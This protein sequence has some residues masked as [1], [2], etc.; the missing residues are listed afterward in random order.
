MLDSLTS[1]L[2]SIDSPLLTR[3]GIRLTIK[4]DDL[5]HP[6]VSG[7][8]WRKLK[9]NL[10]Y[11]SKHNFQGVL[12]FGGAF[13][14][15]IYA[16]AMACK[17]ANL[18]CKLII[19]GL[20]LDPNNPTLKLAK[21]SGAELF[22]VDRKTYR[23]RHDSGYLEF[24]HK[25]HPEYWIVPEGGSNDLALLGLKEL[26]MSLPHSDV[27]ACAVGSGGTLAGITLAAPK[28]TQI[29]GV[30]VLKGASTLKH[31]VLA[32][33]PSLSAYDN[34]LINDE[35]H[36]G[37]Y[38]RFSDK[39]WQFCQQFQHHY[40]VPLEPIYT[41]KLLYGLWDKIS[42]GYFPSGSHII[43]IHTGG[44]QGLMGLKYRGLIS[45]LSR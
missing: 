28:T 30:A 5:N 36:D 1:P 18:K 6:L 7:N 19:R 11:A 29:F 17:L 38:G 40:N 33:Y 34:W 25:E 24:L 39:L 23:L 27:I 8:K 31:D 4:R 22:P 2:Q 12:T 35:Y 20:P 32:N 37:G 45:S 44:L 3:H 10:E 26:T 13:S 21:A 42:Q 15:H 43:A 14:N 9:F 16:T 41:G